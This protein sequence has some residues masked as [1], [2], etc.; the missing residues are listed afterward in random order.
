MLLQAFLGKAPLDVALAR[1]ILKMFSLP[2]QLTAGYYLMS[3]TLIAVFYAGYKHTTLS[4]RE[5]FPLLWF[6]FTFLFLNLHW[7]HHPYYK[8]LLFPSLAVF[9]AVFWTGRLKVGKSHLSGVGVKSRS[10]D[11]S[12][13]VL[14]RN[15]SIFLVRQLSVE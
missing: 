15:D 12:R 3:L 1:L 5:L 8:V 11:L 13:Q 2:I 9:N 7:K 14:I 6:I 10:S 4:R